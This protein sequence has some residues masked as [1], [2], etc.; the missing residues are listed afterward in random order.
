MRNINSVA[1]WAVLAIVAIACTSL[2][3]GFLRTGKMPVDGILVLF[4][5]VALGRR[6]REQRA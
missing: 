6:Y 2:L 5:L 3:E 4:G 1:K